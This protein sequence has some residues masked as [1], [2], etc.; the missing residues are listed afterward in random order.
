MNKRME[1][2]FADLTANA[3]QGIKV[4]KSNENNK[5]IFHVEGPQDSVY[6]GANFKISCTFPENY[7]FKMPEFKFDTLIWHP[8][9]LENGEVCKEM[10]GEKEWVPTKQIKGV[11]EILVNMLA[12]PNLDSAINNEALKQ[13]KEDPDTF[14]KTA[15][16]WV[17][18]HCH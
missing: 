9:V 18:K 1:K 16:Q 7:P 17:A 12:Q 13:F 15:Q 11:I 14:K 3:P 10:L 5:W 6:A 2:E 4:E 8:N